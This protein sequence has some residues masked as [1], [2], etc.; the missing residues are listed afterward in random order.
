[1]QKEP[2]YSWNVVILSGNKQEED[3]ET[4]LGAE[5]SRF[6]RIL[7]AVNLLTD[8]MLFVGK[9]HSAH[10]F[11]IDSELLLSNATPATQ[12]SNS[13]TRRWKRKEE[14]SW[15]RCQCCCGLRGVEKE[16]R[17]VWGGKEDMGWWKG[18]VEDED[19]GCGRILSIGLIKNLR[20]QSLGVQ[21]LMITKWKTPASNKSVN[22][23]PGLLT[24]PNSYRPS[25]GSLPSCARK[26]RR[27]RSK[28]NQSG[29]KNSYSPTHRQG[30]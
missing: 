15:R 14:E 30:F 16:K 28:G 23:R 11:Q 19:Q 6:Q 26:S 21:E 20:L 9:L 25:R 24:C 22:V 18:R 8:V 29:F 17:R 27:E 4:R 7:W 13:G 1:M 5:D 2:K 12:E 3:V 10:L